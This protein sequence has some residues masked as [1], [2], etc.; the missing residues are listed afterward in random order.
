[1]ADIEGMT[2]AYGSGT[3]GYLIVSSQGDSTLAVYDRA[4]GAFVKSFTVAGSGTVD[5]VSDTDGVDV[6]TASAGP[7]F[8]HGLLVVHDGTNT[9]GTYSNLK[10][11][12]LEQVVTMQ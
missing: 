3:S 1:V 5:G 9:G 11:V 7:G 6:V 12:P 8:E 4:T 10:Y 2:I